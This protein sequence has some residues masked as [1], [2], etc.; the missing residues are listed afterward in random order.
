MQPPLSIPVLALWLA[1]SRSVWEY[2]LPTTATESMYNSCA[3]A[4]GSPAA[5]NN[6]LLLGRFQ[7]IFRAGPP[8]G[9]S[10]TAFAH[11]PAHLQTHHTK[12]THHHHHFQ[13]MPTQPPSTLP[14]RPADD[15]AP[16]PSKALWLGVFYLCMPTGVAVGYLF[17]GALGSG[18]WG[19]CAA[20]GCCC[21]CLD[22]K[23]CTWLPTELKV[24]WCR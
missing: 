4:A 21:C 7:D 5:E 14:C 10:G 3:A 13:N 12:R 6:G 2:N 9:W 1:T 11:P 17:G 16:P 24:P 20:G 18:A 22:A 15:H 23:A 8:F 19:P